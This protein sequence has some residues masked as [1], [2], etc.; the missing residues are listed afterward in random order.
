MC[1]ALFLFSGICLAQAPKQVGGFILGSNISEYQDKLNMETAL[2]IRYRECLTEVEIKKREGFKTG[3]I[4]YGNCAVP[5]RIV[6]VKLKYADPSKKFYDALLE[7]FKARFGES[8]EWRGDPFHIMI[9][10][11]W[12]F[13]DSNNNKITMVL[14]HNTKDAEEKLGNA[15]K[16]TVTNLIN[17]ERLCFQKKHPKFRD[18]NRQHQKRTTAP[19]R[20]DWDRFIPR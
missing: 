12:S 8:I 11:E 16:I 3:L 6:R 7:R 17:Q 15:V 2:P 4:A 9:A 19:G 13:T 14:H 10:W 18:K 1:L 5:G 20:L